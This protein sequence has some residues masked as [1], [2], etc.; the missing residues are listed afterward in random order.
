[1]RFSRSPLASLVAVVALVPAGCG[2][3]PSLT[4]RIDGAQAKRTVEKS[5]AAGMI[6]NRTCV[7]NRAD[8]SPILWDA[9]GADSKRGLVLALA[10]VCRDERSGDRITVYDTKSGREIATF[11][12]G[13]LSLR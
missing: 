6:R 13:S 7:G 11:S 1:M 8:V 2:D 9:M 12:G 3:P 10:R 5:E 4:D